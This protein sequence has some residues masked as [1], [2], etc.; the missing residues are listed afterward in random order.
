MMDLNDLTATELARLDAICLDYEKALRNGNA[1]SIESVIETQ[2]GKHA[3]ILRSELIAVRDEISKGDSTDPARSTFAFTTHALPVSGDA[4]NRL[5]GKLAPIS[6]AVSSARGGWGSCSRRSIHVWTAR[7][8][9]KCCRPE[10]RY[11]TKK[12]ELRYAN[13]LNA[14]HVQ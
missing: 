6:S 11:V 13:A 10:I 8:P 4:P 3:E 14:R 5:V 1:P 9:S 2:A 12:N 7:S